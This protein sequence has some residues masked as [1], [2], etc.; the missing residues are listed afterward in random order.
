[1]LSSFR[2]AFD[3]AQAQ[4]LLLNAPA[5]KTHE[6]NL[7]I[8]LLQMSALEGTYPKLTLIAFAYSSNFPHDPIYI[9]GV[10]LNDPNNLLAHCWHIVVTNHRE[11]TL[12]AFLVS[13]LIL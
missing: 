11:N 13:K 6:L 9:V 3:Y 8:E 4:L 10:T 2:A 1:M 12:H 5:V 7:S